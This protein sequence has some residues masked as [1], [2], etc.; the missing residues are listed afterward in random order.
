MKSLTAVLRGCFVI[1]LFVLAGC[2]SDIPAEIRSRPDPDTTLSQL[3]SAAGPADGQQVRWG[4]EVVSVENRPRDTRVEIV[5]RTLYSDGYPE[6]G[7]RSDG[8]FIAEIDGFVDPVVLAEGQLITVFGEVSGSVNRLIGEYD[9]DF[10]L[11]RVTSYQLWE[12][13][14]SSHYDYPYRRYGYGPWYDP[15]YDPWRRPYYW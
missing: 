7:N 14:S 6:S 2:A 5:S 9:Y 15:W 10:I 8:R 12:K 1:G 11:V 13:R 4:G 3:R